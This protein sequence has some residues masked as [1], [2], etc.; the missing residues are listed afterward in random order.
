MGFSRGDSSGRI[1][2][3]P[4][5]G[6][7]NRLNHLRIA[8]F[9]VRGVLSDTNISIGPSLSNVSPS[10]SSTSLRGIETGFEFSDDGTGTRMGSV[11]SDSAAIVHQ[12]YDHIADTPGMLLEGRDTDSGRPKKGIPVVGSHGDAGLP[13]EL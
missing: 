10:A 2:L 6:L 4:F 5:N 11:F 1:S 8:S 13:K 7:C 3:Q 9:E 12:I